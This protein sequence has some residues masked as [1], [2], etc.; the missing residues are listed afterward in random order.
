MRDSD[1]DDDRPRKR[2]RGYSED[3]D[4]PRNCP[5]RR[6]FAA[7]KKRAAPAPILGLSTAGFVLL[8]G[9]GIG[10]Y[11]LVRDTSKPAASDLIVHAPTD[12]IILSGYDFDALSRNDAFRKAMVPQRHPTSWNWIELDCEP[13]ICRAC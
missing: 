5:R 13:R 2:S 11:L 9:I 7:S 4:R 12:A 10:I 6:E 3:V 1:I 8:L